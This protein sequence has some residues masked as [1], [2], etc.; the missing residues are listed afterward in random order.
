MIHRKR[1][2]CVVA[3]H[4]LDRV[5][6]S[7][8]GRQTAYTLDGSPGVMAIATASG[9]GLG[10]GGGGGMGGSHGGGGWVGEER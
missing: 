7:T 5:N 10:G 1:A 8:Y 2:T 4:D 3:R 6:S 9:A